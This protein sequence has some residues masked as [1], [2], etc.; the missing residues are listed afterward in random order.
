ML[1]YKRQLTILIGFT[2]FVSLGLP[3]GLLGVAYPSIRQ[4][5]GIPLESLGTMLF[6]F[7]LG[8]LVSSFNA[9][10]LIAGL[11]IGKLLVI[12][13]LATGIGL[14]GYALAPS[15]G[16]FV[17][18]A[19][20]GGL[21]AGA[22]DAGMNTYGATRFSPRAMQ[23]LHGFYGIG[24]TTGP[25]IMTAVLASSGIWQ[26]GYWIVAVVQLLLAVVFVFT[27]NMWTLTPHTNS[28]GEAIGEGADKPA[29]VRSIDTLRQPIVWVSILSFFVY[30]WLEISGGQWFY[31]LLTTSR[32]LDTITAGTWVSLFW[33]AFSGGRFVIGALANRIAPRKLMR[34]CIVGV[35]LGITLIGLNSP[36]LPSWIALIGMILLGISLAPMYASMTIMTP[37]R[38]GIHTANAIG[39]HATATMFGVFISPTVIGSLAQSTS[40]EVLIPVMLFTGVIFITLFE[41]LMAYDRARAREK[42][43]R[44]SSGA[45]ASV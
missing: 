14:I 22:I 11:G 24:A 21:G 37:K 9:G 4:T 27:R 42:Q 29:H 15:W 12:S 43:T 31:T 33:G 45:A 17:S 13:C 16:I 2:A 44:L 40:I 28:A 36:T 35:M 39:F 3:D 23:W 7:T 20:L 5:F 18:F 1:R 34:I 8:Y 30:V 41:V 10:R 26:Q 32:G 38:L 25:L 19:V 6:M